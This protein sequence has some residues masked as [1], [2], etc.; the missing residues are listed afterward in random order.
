MDLFLSRS[1]GTTVYATKNG[2]IFGP[3]TLQ[4]MDGILDWPVE[5]QETAKLICNISGYKV[6]VLIHIDETDDEIRCTPIY[7]LESE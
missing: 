4:K 7:K 2:V 1:E 5:V 6:V 3:V